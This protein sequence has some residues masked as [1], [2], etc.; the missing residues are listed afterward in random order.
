MDGK[1]KEKPA[2]QFHSIA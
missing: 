1:K 2:A